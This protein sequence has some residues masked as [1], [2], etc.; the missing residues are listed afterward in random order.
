MIYL[1]LD[2]IKQHLNIN[3]EFTADDAYL[4]SLADVAEAAVQNHIDESLESIMTRNGGELPPPIRHCMLMFIGTLY[5]QREHLTPVNMS[6]VPLAYRYLLQ[7]YKNYKK[8]QI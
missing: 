6:E 7:Q 1:D 3:T 5:M 8:S 2:I 4:E